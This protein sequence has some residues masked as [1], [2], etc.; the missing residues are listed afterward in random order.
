MLLQLTPG[1]PV[2]IMLGLEASQSQLDA[3]RAELWLDRPLPVQYW[4]WISNFVQGDLGTSIIYDRSVASLLQKRI[5]ITLYLGTLAMLLSIVVGVST[6]TIAAMK[7]GRLAD[8]AV[9]LFVTL[10]ISVPVFWLGVL[11]MYTFSLRLGWLPIQGYTSP[12]VDVVK[13][14]KQVIMPVI[15]LSVV[16]TAVIARQQR[17]ALLEV[18]GQDY[19]RTARSKGLRESAVVMKHATRNA[20]IPVITILGINVRYLVGGSVLVES[21]FNIPGMGRLIADATMNRDFITMQACVTLIAIVVVLASL[22]V[23]ISYAFVD[24]RVRYD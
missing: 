10:G 21:V 13:S 2:L 18:L 15:C 7:R 20:L 5:P 17:S 11:G 19:I 1:D 6:G 9:S 3:L 22:A 23:D 4:H 24:P 14:I 16:P 12:F 8:S